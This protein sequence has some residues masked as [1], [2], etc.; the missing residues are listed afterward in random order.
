M[1]FVE[2]SYKAPSVHKIAPILSHICFSFDIGLFINDL[3][4]PT[5]A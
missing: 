3:E 5:G 4:R 1:L 2:H